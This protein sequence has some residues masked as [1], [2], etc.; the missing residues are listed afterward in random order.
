VENYIVPIGH[1]ENVENLENITVELL[2]T[3]LERANE[4]FHIVPDVF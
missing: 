3:R 1:A 4:N 2:Y